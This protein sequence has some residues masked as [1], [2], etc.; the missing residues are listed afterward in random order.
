MR[1]PHPEANPAAGV[2]WETMRVNFWRNN[3]ADPKSHGHLIDAEFQLHRWKTALT[4]ELQR[5]GVY[6]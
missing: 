3:S 4:A 2:A 5:L 1:R 6:Q